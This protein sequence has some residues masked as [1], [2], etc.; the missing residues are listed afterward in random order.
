MDGILES[1]QVGEHLGDLGRVAHL[2]RA[3]NLQ[4]ISPYLALG[5]SSIWLFLSCILLFKNKTKQN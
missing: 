5:I 3:W 4:A 2:E 1:S